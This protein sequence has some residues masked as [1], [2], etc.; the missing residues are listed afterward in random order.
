MGKK[1]RD[2]KTDMA[3]LLILVGTESGNAEM[4]AEKLRDD[5]GLVGYQVEIKTDFSDVERVFVDRELVLVCCATRGSGDLP[6]NILPLK[7]HL[8]AVPQYLGHIRYGVIALGDQS[9]D[10][11]FCGGGK[12][13]DETLADLGATRIGERLE[14]DACSEQAP[15]E[16]ALAWCRDW[17]TQL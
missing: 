6:D 11:T 2:G 7:M 14:I 4:V 10:E 13:L 3:E 15:D 17:V 9:Y 1:T 8:D 12:L 16:V 5:L